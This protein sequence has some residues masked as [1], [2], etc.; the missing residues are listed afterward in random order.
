MKLTTRGMAGKLAL[1]GAKIAE[2]GVK[3]NKRKK[4]LKM[5]LHVT[6]MVQVSAGIYVA[7]KAIGALEDITLK[8]QLKVP[9]GLYN[10]L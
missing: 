6:V 4:V 1:I 5:L 8:T 2:A 10:R 7:D 9:I 3:Q